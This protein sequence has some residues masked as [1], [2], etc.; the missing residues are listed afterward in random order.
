MIWFPLSC[1][2]G[3]TDPRWR[4]NWPILT[5]DFFCRSAFPGSVV[6]Q[7]N[8]SELSRFR[9]W[10]TCQHA[11]SLGRPSI[12]ISFSLPLLH[13]SFGS[14]FIWLTP[15]STIYSVM[16]LSFHDM[17]R[18]VFESSAFHPTKVAPCSFKL[19]GPFIF[20]AMRYHHIPIDRPLNVLSEI[21]WLQ[22][23]TIKRL[24]AKFE[25]WTKVDI[26][27]HQGRLLKF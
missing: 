6:I 1:A 17:S 25:K 16:I 26:D 23:D 24:F 27:P 21:F 3:R 12:W 9:D 4:L 19:H 5:S 15:T 8:K 7:A 14:P 10:K 22:I 13:C 11:P 20:I 18:F 2:I